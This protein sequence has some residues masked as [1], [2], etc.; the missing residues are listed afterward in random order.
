[1]SSLPPVG[2]P[3][4]GMRVFTRPAAAS[5]ATRTRRGPSP[6]RAPHRA[7]TAAPSRRGGVSAPQ[8]CTCESAMSIVDDSPLRAR[9]LVAKPL[10]ALLQVRHAIVH[11]LR[12]ARRLT[13]LLRRPPRL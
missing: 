9:L 6:S 3:D 8:M 4:P 12:E 10:Q 11:L 2:F 7:A 13:A 1:M 5:R